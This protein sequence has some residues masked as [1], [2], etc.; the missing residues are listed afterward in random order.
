MKVIS[1]IVLLITSMVC[2]GNKRVP[3]T[4]T[5]NSIIISILV[6]ITTKTVSPIRSSQTTIKLT[7]M[8]SL[9]MGKS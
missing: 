3:V 9:T 5:N 1:V 4:I 6:L 2:C 7:V 8:I